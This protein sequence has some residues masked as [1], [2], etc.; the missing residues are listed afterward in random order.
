MSDIDPAD[1]TVSGR[2]PLPETFNPDFVEGAVA[3]P[4][5]PEREGLPPGYRMRADAHYVDQLTTRRSHG[6]SVRG[7]ARDTEAADA[8]GSAEV[9]DRHESRDRR[10]DRAFAQLSEDLATIGSAAALLGDDTSVLGRRV[11]LDL[12]K[13][14]AWR[15]SWLLGAQALLDNPHRGHFR[16]R[17]VA[18]LL[19]RVRDGFAPECRLNAIVL[20]VRGSDWHA[21]MPVDEPGLMAGVGGALV[22]TLGLIGPSEGATIKITLTMAGEAPT[23]EIAQDVATIPA[24]VGQRFF[25]PSWSDR[26][27]GWIVGIGAAAARTAALQHGGRAAFVLGDVRG[28]ALHLTLARTS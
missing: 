4:R 23:I 19:G 15:A 2:R 21:S 24:S 27:G 6:E 3:A 5:K 9:R 12:I 26:P 17:S 10:S 7:L 20:D 8:E 1:A 28:S 13:A 22:A 16:P 14:H 25:D 11:S 18:A